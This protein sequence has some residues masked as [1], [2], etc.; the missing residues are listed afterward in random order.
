MNDPIARET[1]GRAGHGRLRATKAQVLQ[2]VRAA[3]GQN[4]ARYT[5]AVD[6]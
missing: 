3:L 6:S 4:E 1:T 5:D 2:Y